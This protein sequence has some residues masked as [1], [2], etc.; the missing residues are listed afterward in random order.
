MAN[1]YWIRG[2]AG[3]WNDTANWSTSSGGAG[4]ASVPGSGDAAIF[5]AN[6]AGNCTLDISITVQSLTVGSGYTG[7]FDANDFDINCGNCIVVGT[8]SRLAGSGTWTVSGDWN[9]RSGSGFNKE[10]STIVWTGTSKGHTSGD[11][12]LGFNNLTVSGSYSG[13]WGLSVNGT[14]T[15]DGT[16]TCNSNSLVAGGSVVVNGTLAG[17]TT[18]VIGL[19]SGTVV[20]SGT[21]TISSA[22][23]FG[24]GVNFVQ[25]FRFGATAPIMTGSVS[26]GNPVWTQTVT[27]DLA[28]NNPDLE[29][30][31]DVA[32]D[33][34]AK[35]VTWTKG[36]G[37]ITL[38]G[39]ANQAIDFDGK[40]IEDLEV[41]K[42]A[43]TAT[44]DANFDT[45]SLTLTDGTLDI[46][47][48]DIG[49]T[50]GT[51]V[52]AGCVVQDTATGGLI[53]VGGNFAIN[54]TSGN[55]VTWNGPDLDIT[56]TAAA[57]Y[58]DVTNS[59]A[60][61]GTEVTATNSTDN[62]GNTNWSFGATTGHGRL[63]SRSRNRLVVC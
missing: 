40:T 60:S 6:G 54:G 63:L 49:V 18:Q 46:D 29:F 56:G 36:T 11:G 31:G 62:G 53:T 7:T 24:L 52:A 32:I 5:D 15:V 39:S 30:R 61:A 3:S 47:G 14:L 25:T 28:T 35:G 20:V 37:T 50:G 21:G 41:N 34:W 22:V 38:S 1:R 9:D 55:E 26:F 58:A 8:A 59:D 19:A 33:P 17:N 4:G 43:G 51:T 48:F 44:L 57:D 12:A 42:S 2:T 45:D 13:V 27:V 10:T 16:L 23:R